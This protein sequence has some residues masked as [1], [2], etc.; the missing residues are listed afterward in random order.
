MA[1]LASKYTGE[2]FHEGTAFFK[3]G[4]TRQYNFSNLKVLAHRIY[5][6]PLQEVKILS[7]GLEIPIIYRWKHYKGKLINTTAG[8]TYFH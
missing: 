3:H 8:D 2:M 5:Y 6:S 4:V 1:R 7:V